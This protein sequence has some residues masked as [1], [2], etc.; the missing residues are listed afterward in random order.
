MEYSFEFF[1][2][3]LF[4][5]VLAA[6]LEVWARMSEAGRNIM[7][8]LDSPPV[9]SDEQQV[10][11]E[12]AREKRQRLEALDAYNEACN[13]EPFCGGAEK[14]SRE[15]IGKA[16][17]AARDSRTKKPPHQSAYQA[18]H[19]DGFA[20]PIVAQGLMDDSSPSSRPSFSGGGGS[21]DG[22]G[23]SGDWGGSSSG[24]SSSSD[25]SSSSSDSGSSSCSSSD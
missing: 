7:A 23:A 24:S 15:A 25:C 22:G 3:V 19:D 20:L 6:G 5:V 9:K 11:E 16:L 10:A 8:T 13:M 21:F 4:V 17:K 1:A 18:P 12:L 2:L 14:R